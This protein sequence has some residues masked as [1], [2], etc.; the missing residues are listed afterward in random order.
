LAYDYV[1]VSGSFPG[2]SGTV[3]FTP[4]S[5]VTDLTG[6]ITVLGPVSFACQLSGGSFTSP[7]LLATDNPG[8]LPAGW[9]WEVLVRLQGAAPYGH[10]ALIPSS[11]AITTLAALPVSASTASTAA[12]TSID[13]GSA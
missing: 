4:S 8:L 3:T 11:P 1:T 12:V 6:A 7:A 10:P 2:Q 5:A 9:T 13:G